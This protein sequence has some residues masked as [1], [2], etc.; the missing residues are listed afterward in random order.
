MKI[1]DETSW[2]KWRDANMDSGY[3]QAVIEYA[4]RWANLIEERAGGDEALLTSV[5]KQASHDANTD[6]ITRFMYGA[7][8]SVLATSWA[9][10][11]TLRR[12]HNLETQ[13][14]HEGERANAGT[15][16]LNPA[17]L[18]LEETP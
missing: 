11:E 3:G 8:V 14:G 13:I 10:G 12:W 15:G 6:G 1:S 4:E 16:V 18:N 7:A 2:K 17:L 5:A 9:W